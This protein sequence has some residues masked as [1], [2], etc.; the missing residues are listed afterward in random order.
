MRKFLIFLMLF[1][2]NIAMACLVPSKVGDAFIADA[3]I[4]PDMAGCTDIQLLLHKKVLGDN[5]YVSRIYVDIVSNE[6]KFVSSFFPRYEHVTQGK[7][8]VSLCVAPDYIEK[9]IFALEL[10]SEPIIELGGG[11]GYSVAITECS[12]TAHINLQTLVTENATKSKK[13]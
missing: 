7:I 11:A 9:S 12:Q 6:G 13:P 8:L 10:K 3:K 4:T 1:V 2:S 5:Q